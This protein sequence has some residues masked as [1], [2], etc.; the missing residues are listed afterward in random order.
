MQE[1]TTAYF[2]FQKNSTFKHW[3][4]TYIWISWYIWFYLYLGTL[5]VHGNNSIIQMNKHFSESL[6][7]V[8]KKIC[9]FSLSCNE[10][11][12]QHQSKDGINMMFSVN[13]QIRLLSDVSVVAR[14]YLFTNNTDDLV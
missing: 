2:N 9:Y 5:I 13:L 4:R 8:K 1:T 14:D 11:N 7:N 12:Q 10:D 6:Q 3:S